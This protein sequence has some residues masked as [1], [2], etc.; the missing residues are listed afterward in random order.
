MLPRAARRL[1]QEAL[2]ERLP[3][4]RAVSATATQQPVVSPI[5]IEMNDSRQALSSFDVVFTAAQ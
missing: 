3:R 2:R 4:A 5:S 1:A